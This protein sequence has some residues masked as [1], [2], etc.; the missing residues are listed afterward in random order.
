MLSNE[1]LMAFLGIYP[2]V[3]VYSLRTGK[4]PF[5]S[6]VNHHVYH[7]FL[8]AMAL[9]NNQGVGSEKTCPTGNDH[10]LWLQVMNVLVLLLPFALA[11]SDCGE[12]LIVENPC[13]S[14]R[15]V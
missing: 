12:A 1:Y 15:W 8:W 2:L 6:S 11:A 7:L 4:S 13:L 10:D 9:T 14:L 5:L 3:N